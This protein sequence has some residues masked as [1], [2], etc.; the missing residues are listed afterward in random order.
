MTFVQQPRERAC[1]CVRVCACVDASRENVRPETP[2]GS[3]TPRESENPDR[4]QESDRM[5][6]GEE[7]DGDT[8]SMESDI[9]RDEEPPR[10]A[11]DEQEEDAMEEPKTDELLSLSWG[12]KR[13]EKQKR[14][15]RK[16][17]REERRNKREERG[18]K[19]A[20]R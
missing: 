1:V 12:E 7:R 9:M 8:S 11:P 5:S 15:V 19:R 13:G 17:E 20:K 4:D 14:E 10:D 16:E 2:R 18:E 6:K 3:E